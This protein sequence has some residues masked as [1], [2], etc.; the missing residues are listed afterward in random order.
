MNSVGYELNPLQKAIWFER[1]H[2]AAC[3][4]GQSQYN[5]EKNINSLQH[6]S[7][8]A[9]TSISHVLGN[10]MEAASLLQ[11]HVSSGTSSLHDYNGAQFLGT[12]AQTGVGI[13]YR[14]F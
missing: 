10:C 4:F 13:N 6:V 7:R 5:Q 11:L 14:L 1:I 8:S 3:N 9:S 2:K 12:S